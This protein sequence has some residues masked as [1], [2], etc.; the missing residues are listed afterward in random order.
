MYQIGLSEE[1]TA[2]RLRTEALAIA[3]IVALQT[4]LGRR[5]VH[6][7]GP[8]PAVQAVAKSASQRKPKAPAKA[9][10]VAKPVMLSGEAFFDARMLACR[11]VAAEHGAAWH[12]VEGAS[13]WGT[14]PPKLRRFTTA[15]GSV[16]KAKPDARLPAAHY[17]P[18]AELPVG[19]ELQPDGPREVWHPAIIERRKVERW[20]WQAAGAYR[21]AVAMIRHTRW[22]MREGEGTREEYQDAI[23]DAW[24][25]RAAWRALVAKLNAIPEPGPAPTAVARGMTPWVKGPWGR[26][27]ETIEI[28]PMLASLADARAAQSEANEL[29]AMHVMFDDMARKRVSSG[30]AWTWTN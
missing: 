16:C 26:K 20:T 28:H 2:P 11:A 3:G 13:Y 7:V 29:W 23:A 22:A 10:R 1:S 8:L 17:W 5:A 6:W 18:G 9:Q 4:M 24:A 21:S 14:I 15:R 25:K 19:I 27:G 12:L 30:R